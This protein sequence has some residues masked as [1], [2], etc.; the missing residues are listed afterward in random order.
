MG[1]IVDGFNSLWDRLAE[2][3]S[4]H[5][6]RIRTCLILLLVAWLCWDVYQFEQEKPEEVIYNDFVKMVDDGL[7][8]TIY[9]EANTEKMRFTLYNEYTKG[10]TQEELEKEKYEYPKEDWG[11]TYYP[12]TETF[13]EDM[14][15][16]GVHL[17]VKTFE[18]II[19][20]LIGVAVSLFFPILMVVLL[21][22]YFSLVSGKNTNAF[23]LSEDV[24]TRFTD[25]IGHDEVIKDLNFI[26]DIMRKPN[27]YKEESGIKV[28]KGILFN[29][30][31]GTGKTLLARAIAGESSVPF[32]YVN[33]SN[34]IELYVGTGAKRVRSLFKEARKNAP[35]IVFI[36]EIDAIGGHRGFMSN[37][38]NHQTINALL[39]ELDGFNQDENILVIGATNNAEML[40]RALVRSGRFDRQIIIAPPKDAKERITMLEYFLKDKK[41]S[42]DVNLELLAK[43]MVGYTGADINSVVNEAGLIALSKAD[44]DM[45]IITMAMLE[46]AF[47]KK[48]LQGNRIKNK[49]KSE[50][51]KI[52]AY[53]EAG[54]AVMSYLLEVPIARAS[55]I[56][57]TSGVGGMVVNQDDDS[58]FVTDKK[59]RDDIKIMYGGRISES[60]KFNTVTNG[61]SS[62]IKKAT[63]LLQTYVGQFG[64]DSELG[65]LNLDML[66]SEMRSTDIKL[67]KISELS[68]TLEKETRELLTKNYHLVEALAQ[69]LLDK[70]TLGEGAI[71]EILD[72]SIKE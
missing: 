6:D 65:L 62:D 2:F 44:G 27:K 45:P 63:Q 14:L 50:D 11:M 12:A 43:Q 59:L 24:D 51:L 31:P 13:R 3:C 71:K 5:K 47:D 34:F 39:Q 32:Y 58:H 29:G 72:T 23:E 70:E 10:K 21:L 57:T 53:H 17:E 1:W 19:V 69:E 15:K 30:P 46:E 36:D 33:A 8:D 66:D 38:E 49:E 9:Y 56:G 16:K 64:F 68:K 40:D 61:A 67:R 60:I 4:L 54:H 42:D 55:I 37:S 41:L 26:V 35:C 7:V 25:V 52:V 22:N 28:P 18:P 20:S 48:I